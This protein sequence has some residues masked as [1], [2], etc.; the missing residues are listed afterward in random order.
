MKVPEDEISSQYLLSVFSVACNLGPFGTV[1]ADVC[2][3]PVANKVKPKIMDV[4]TIALFLQYCCRQNG[5]SNF[6]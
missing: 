3:V 5:G 6:T 1:G 2:G 4:N